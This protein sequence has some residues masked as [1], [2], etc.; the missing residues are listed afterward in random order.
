MEKQIVPDLDYLIA[1]N[2]DVADLRGLFAKLTVK[3]NDVNNTNLE[4]DLKPLFLDQGFIVNWLR[5]WREN[6]LRLLKAY[7]IH[8]VTNLREIVIHE[9]FH[10][11]NFS[12]VFYYETTDGKTVNIIYTISDYWI[13]FGDGNLQIP[14]DE[15][16]A[17]KIHFSANGVSSKTTPQEKLKQYATLFYQK[18]EAYFKKTRRE[19]LR[20]VIRTKII[21]MTADNLNQAEQIVLDRSALVACDL[22]DLLK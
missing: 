12:F 13:T 2:I 8:T 22:D 16:I 19:M 21:R 18:T 20:D 11:D 4:Q 1:K 5:S 6:Y 9:D 15:T 14:V 3:M 17:E 7:T 10:T